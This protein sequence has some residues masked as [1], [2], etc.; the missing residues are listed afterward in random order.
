MKRILLIVLL[1]NQMC[2]ANASLEISILTC[3]PGDE[4][5][6]IFGHSAIRILDKENQIDKVYDFGTFDFDTP[7]F[8]YK[9]LKG[10]L[11]YHLSV[12]NTNQF[13]RAYT[14]ENREVLEQQLHFSE[15]EK[16]QIVDRLD[17]LFQPENRYYF[18]SFLEKDCST[19]LRD[20]L[21][22][23]GVQFSDE[24][25]NESKRDLINTYLTEKSWIKL[26]VNII[27]GQ[28]LDAMSSRF[29]SM[30]LPKYLKKEIELATLHNVSLV[31]SEQKLNE[32]KTNRSKN[33]AIKLF[34]PTVIFSIFLLLY[35]IGFQK[36][37]SLLLFLG[38][39][40]SGLI[41]AFLWGFSGHEE[42]TKNLNI[43]WCNPLYLLS[44]P[45]LLKKKTNS[46]LTMLLV[47]FLVIA[48]GIWVFGVQQLD[49][50]IIPLLFTLGL[51]HYNEFKKILTLSK[52]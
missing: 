30:F 35:V 48:I 52:P 22:M 20:L 45:L 21:T 39:G 43:L 8:A 6:S 42:V 12:R 47:F 32:V 1:F 24:L 16:G 38:I 3:A 25:L 11:K 10:K 5:Y 40:I 29:Q 9:F 31:K 23:V 41:I 19:D 14:Y 28:R 18:Y 2:Y 49:Q 4:I 34:S 7:N 37:I 27:L 26:G 33:K 51:I 17:F 44:I 15:L 50:S 46:I 13:I 36:A